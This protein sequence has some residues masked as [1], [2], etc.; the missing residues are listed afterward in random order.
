LKENYQDYHMLKFP[1]PGDEYIAFPSPEGG[2][3]QFPS[4]SGRG[5]RGE[6]RRN[7]VSLGEGACIYSHALELRP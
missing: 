6:G 1:H 7:K 2:R 5:V 4:P 3:E